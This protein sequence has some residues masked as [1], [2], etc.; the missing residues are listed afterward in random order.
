MRYAMKSFLILLFLGMV[1]ALGRCG[2]L[3]N[4][5]KDDLK[6]DDILYIPDGWDGE[7]DWSS[8]ALKVEDVAP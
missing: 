8:N 6:P 3:S 7:E 5:P 4:G 2:R 1:L